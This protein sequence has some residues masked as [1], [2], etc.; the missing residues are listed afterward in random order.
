MSNEL[1]WEFYQDN[2]KEWRWRAKSANGKTVASSGEGFASKQNAIK[3]A[4]F[5]GYK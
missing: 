2:K 4:K 3:N 1:T 5:S